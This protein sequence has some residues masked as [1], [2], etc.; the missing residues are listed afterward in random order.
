MRRPNNKAQQKLIRAFYNVLQSA[1]QTNYGNYA[2]STTPPPLLL[3]S[4]VTFRAVN[5]RQMLGTIWC[6]NV[7]FHE[8]FIGSYKDE[9]G[10]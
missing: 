9:K 2:S 7:K 10:K 1:D 5:K 6:E 3:R 8:H 4:R